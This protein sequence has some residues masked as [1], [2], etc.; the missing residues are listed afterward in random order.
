MNKAGKICLGVFIPIIIF[1]IVFLL[2]IFI[3]YS[4]SLDQYTYTVKEKLGPYKQTIPKKIHQ[5]WT[6]EK[7]P[8]KFKKIQKHLQ[9]QN[10][11]YTYHLYNEEQMD[12]FVKTHFPQYYKSYSLIAP[13]YIIAKCDFFRYMIIY[14]FGGVYFDMKSGAKK[15]LRE[16]IKSDDEMVIPV[17][18]NIGKI[19]PRIDT[20]AQWVI[21]AKPQHP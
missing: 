20:Y 11:E 8:K 2:L 21:I 19:F 5:I 7:I 15:P 16:I 18:N 1:I 4:N 12:N 14:H 17:W 13:E 10:P 3:P 9:K 6:G